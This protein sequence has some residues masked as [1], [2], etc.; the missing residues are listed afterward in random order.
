MTYFDEP[1]YG[2]FPQQKHSG[3]RIA[4]FFVR[5]GAG[6]V[7]LVLCTIAGVVEASTPAG[8]DENSPVAIALGAGLIAALVA[9]LFGV[10][11]GIGALFQRDRRK[12]FAVLGVVFGCL[13][14]FGLCVLG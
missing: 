2:G 14:L 10:G 8:M 3:L 1:P 5:V 11:L 9:N 7:V 4:P 12:V 6:L 13:A